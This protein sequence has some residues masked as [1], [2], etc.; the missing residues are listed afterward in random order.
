MR[1]IVPLTLLV[2][3]TVTGRTELQLAQKGVARTV[4]VVDSAATATEAFAARELAAEGA[5]AESKWKL[6]WS[7][8]FDVVGRPDPTRWTNE[9]G[10][11][12]NRERQYYT[13]GRPENARVENGRLMTKSI[14]PTR[15]NWRPGKTSGPSTS[16][17]T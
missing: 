12:R 5:Q 13:A 17:A 9:V 14:S 11:L 4:I 7:D 2:A 10:F 1:R 6:A 16:R 15:R 3:T 8:E